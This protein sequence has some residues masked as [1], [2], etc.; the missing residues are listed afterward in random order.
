MANLFDV[1]TVSFGKAKDARIAELETENAARLTIEEGVAL[2]EAEAHR[3]RQRDEEIARNAGL[4]ERI[5]ELETDA[6]SWA[7]LVEAD[8]VT[9][10][11][12]RRRITELETELA[13]FREYVAANA[14]ETEAQADGEASPPAQVAKPKK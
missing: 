3:T 10:E 5:A 4:G 13:P 11:E 2:E 12:Q 6:K 7:S 9:Q 8:V 1:F 14:A